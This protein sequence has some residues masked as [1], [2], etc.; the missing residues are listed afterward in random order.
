MTEPN[1]DELP[2]KFKGPVRKLRQAAGEGSIAIITNGKNPKNWS[3]E[4]WLL[5][6]GAV[7]AA[8]ATVFQATFALGGEYRASKDTLVALNATVSELT[9]AVDEVIPQLVQIRDEQ[10]A[11][12]RQIQLLESFHGIGRP[13]VQSPASADRVRPMFSRDDQFAVEARP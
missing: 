12:V 1:W 6:I 10:Q 7:C 9:S 5:V 13:M 2:A 11:V 8:T 3:V 4:R